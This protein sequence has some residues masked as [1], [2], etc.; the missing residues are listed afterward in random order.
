MSCH[1]IGSHGGSVGPELTAIAKDQP[2]SDFI[3]SVFWPRRGVKP[4]HTTG[5]ILSD[6]GEVFTGY[7]ISETEQEVVIREPSCLCRIPHRLDA[8]WQ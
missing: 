6:G 5:T 2:L 7:K 4:E 1:K 8:I 3:E